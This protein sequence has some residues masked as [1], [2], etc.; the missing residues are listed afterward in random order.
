MSREKLGMP[1]NRVYETNREAVLQYIHSHNPVSQKDIAN[2]VGLKQPTVSKIVRELINANIIEKKVLAEEKRSKG[3]PPEYLK[4]T[5]KLLALA[6]R[7]ARN[8][9]ISA[10]VDIDGNVYERTDH[11]LPSQRGANELINLLEKIIK[12]HQDE[13]SGQQGTLIGFGMA[14]PGPVN[15]K[16][17]KIAKVTGRSDWSG[18]NLTKLENITELPFLI[19]HDAAAAAIGENLFGTT[20]GSSNNIFIA[21]GRG[22]GAGIITNGELVQGSQGYSGEFGHMSIEANGVECPCGNRGCIESYA[23]I[24]SLLRNLKGK[25]EESKSSYPFDELTFDSVVKQVKDSKEVNEAVKEAGYYLGVGIANL[26]NLFG[27]EIIVLGDEMV[28]LGDIWVDKVKKVIKE[29]SLTQY[30]ESLNI[31]TSDL[32]DNF[33]LKGAGALAVEKFLRNSKVWLKNE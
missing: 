33:F 6:I 20:K 16:K 8:K 24:N 15:L 3:R 9:I 10:Y 7:V 5:S 32:N 14:V 17:G 18:L 28:K 31:I 25:L 27:P 1:L 21:A 29:R 12:N 19:R 11:P 2:T 4:I 22:V 13:F 26:V 23:S 30:C